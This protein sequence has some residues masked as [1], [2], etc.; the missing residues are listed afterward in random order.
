MRAGFL[1]L[2]HAE[3]G[4]I[5]GNPSGA[6]GHSV[7]QLEVSIH[8]GDAAIDVCAGLA[9]AQSSP[10]HTNEKNTSFFPVAVWYSGG[11]VRAPM[12]ENITENSP[13]LWKEDLLKIKGLG[14]NTVRTWVEWNVGEPE[15]GKYHLE[16]LDLLLQL[17]NEVDL[18]LIVQVYVD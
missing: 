16:N 5:V 7:R 3:A 6:N 1:P 12:L 8:P 11:K 17:A 10:A 15:E 4:G 13:R 2:H 9:L 18:R 14:F